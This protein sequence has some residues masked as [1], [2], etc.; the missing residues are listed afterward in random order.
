MKYSIL[1]LGGVVWANLVKS[2][3]KSF[4][5][6]LEVG[7]LISIGP[8][9]YR[10]D[11]VRINNITSVFYADKLRYEHPSIRLRAS[12][13][14]KI[15]DAFSAGLEIGSNIRVGESFYNNEVLYSIP[16]QTKLLY[17]LI[18]FN[19]QYS[20]AIDGT[21]GYHFRNYYKIPTTEQ[22]GLIFSSSVVLQK[23]SNKNL[24]WF[25]KVGFEKQTENV[26][27]TIYAR[28]PGQVNQDYK[29]KVFR[30]QLLL[31]LGLTLN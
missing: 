21:I 4:S 16:L 8:N 17:S 14:Y 6:Q 18:Q 20:L 27:R 30:N 7:S 11:S 1:L 3:D 22:G 12:L 5:Y 10:T 9:H 19:K 2:Q 23:K 31:S 29:F 13:L 15:T 24:N 28:D 25:T 26:R